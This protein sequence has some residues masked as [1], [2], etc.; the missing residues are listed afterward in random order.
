MGYQYRPPQ[1]YD[2]NATSR[3]SMAA[4]D[5]AG[6]TP[7]SSNPLPHLTEEQKARMVAERKREEREAEE[8][9][10]LARLEAIRAEEQRV[11]DEK[12]AWLAAEQER[13]MEQ[14]KGLAPTYRDSY[15]A[16]DPQTFKDA[17]R[18]ADETYMQFWY[19]KANA[20]TEHWTDEDYKLLVNPVY[21]RENIREG[22]GRAIYKD[23]RQLP[24][25]YDQYLE[26]Q[27]RIND[28]VLDFTSEEDHRKL[29]NPPSNRGYGKY[30]SWIS[31]DNPL[32]QAVEAQ[33]AV[34]KEWLEEADVDLVI[35]YED[36]DGFR[37]PDPMRGEGIY[38]N[39]GTGAHIDWDSGRLKRMQSYRNV[40]GEEGG[41]GE[42]STSFIRPD[43][44]YGTFG[45][46]LSIIGTITG[47][48][49]MRAIG[50]GLQGGDWKDI[51]KGQ[52]AS[53]I[54]VPVLEE[55]LATLGVDADLLGIDPET[56]TDS[57][58]EVQTAM[59]E[60]ESGM[61]A[62]IGE[63]TEP[64]ADKVVDTVKEVLPDVAGIDI[65]FD[66]PD[67]IK[68]IGDVALAG[69]EA[70][71]DFVEPVAKEVVD[72][73]QAAV[74]VAQ[75]VTQP[76]SDVLSEGE[77]I[78]KEA[79]SVFDDEVIQPALE[80]GEEVVDTIADTGEPVVDFIDDALDTFGEEVVDP[81]LQ[82]IGEVGQDIIDP[83]DDIIDA[84][85]SPLGDI[86]EAGLKLGEAQPTQVGS[87]FNREL[88]EI[89]KHDIIEMP[90]LFSDQ[91]IQGMLSRK[92]RV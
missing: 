15:D 17:K 78:V 39:T 45:K 91:E 32:R 3:G 82:T 18:V 64:L 34:M 2:Q 74:D 24:K 40:G 85:D 49:V 12:A 14:A 20:I 19:D 8:R 88:G 65:D 86:I 51:A 23:V 69:I 76:I 29:I 46:A 84:I 53:Q 61:D 56:F 50:T 57:V 26:I 22:N 27:G 68:D 90:Q 6:M 25:G 71:G 42:Y 9:K 10:E 31:E 5:A 47:N 37:R 75:E 44:D 70:V 38:L 73:G 92:Y 55:T 11:K 59:L 80:F 89:Y 67:I 81:T 87:L 36:L 66:T 33:S 1:W 83:I 28:G 13:L 21:K 35:P 54:S 48:P 58:M 77:D 41:F 63:F 7:T 30:Q 43:P 16:E 72:V 52:L 62:L 60:G 79:G 4:R